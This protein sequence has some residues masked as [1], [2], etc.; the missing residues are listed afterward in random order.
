ML[1]C[2]ACILLINLG[3]KILNLFNF[4]YSANKRLWCSIILSPHCTLV[5]PIG[6]N[7]RE[8]EIELVIILSIIR[9]AYARVRAEE[10]T[11]NVGVLPVDN[12]PGVF[13][14][15]HSGNHPSNNHLALRRQIHNLSVSWHLISWFTSTRLDS[16]FYTLFVFKIRTDGVLPVSTIYIPVHSVHQLIK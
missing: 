9:W 12:F 10:N 3:G 13:F 1:Y 14:G 7:A 11:N 4:S 5:H 2:C 8:C 16:N 6:S 15:H